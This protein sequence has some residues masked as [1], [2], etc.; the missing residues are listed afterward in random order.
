MDAIPERASRKGIRMKREEILRQALQTIA[1]GSTTNPSH[2]AQNALDCYQASFKA[3]QLPIE[4]IYTP[5]EWVCAKTWAAFEE[6]RK[7]LRGPM[8]DLARKG[9][10]EDLMKLRGEYDPTLLLKVA[11]KRGWRGVFPTDEARV[12]TPEVDHARQTQIYLVA[13]VMTAEQ[14]ERNREMARAAKGLARGA[15]RG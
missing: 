4:P 9:I 8:T 6:H 12:S 11:I 14:K 10:L 15:L 5:P 2:I 13:Q 3:K 7:K 1:S